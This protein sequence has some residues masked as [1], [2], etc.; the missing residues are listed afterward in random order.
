MKKMVIKDENNNEIEINFANFTQLLGYNILK[1]QFIIDS[2]VKHFS[3]HRYK[4]E[5]EFMINNIKIDG[6]IC[7]RKYYDTKI[8]SRIDDFDQE[9]SLNKTAILNEYLSTQLNSFDFCK[10]QR[11][12]NSIFE[13]II[14]EINKKMDIEPL[15]FQ[16]T[17]IEYGIKDIIEKNINIDF[18][19]NTQKYYKYYIKNVNKILAYLKILENLNRINPINRLIILKDMDKYLLLAEY[20]KVIVKILKLIDTNNFTFIISTSAERYSYL[21]EERIS[22]LNVVNDKIFNVPSIDILY[23]FILNHYP[24]NINISKAD[25]INLIIPIIHK[26]GVNEEILKFESVVSLK[27]LNK[28]LNIL[29]KPI[30]KPNDLE[31]KYL[32]SNL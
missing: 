30:K 24:Y 14:I 21:D 3:N 15:D 8:F 13:S 5:D 6:E 32:Q 12:I 27:I 10:K 1:K 4:Y 7:G 20:N 19:D 16:I 28:S 2:L 26:I 17:A 22:G 29:N 18:L 9:L 31:L 23:D 11:E 25:L